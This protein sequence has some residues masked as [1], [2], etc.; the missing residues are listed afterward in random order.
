MQ[1]LAWDGWRVA[2]REG[3]SGYPDFIV[4]DSCSQRAVKPL[5]S[6]FVDPEVCE[7]VALF[8]MSRPRWRCMLQRNPE[9]RRSRARDTVRPPYED[10]SYSKLFMSTRV[11]KLF[12]TAMPDSVSRLLM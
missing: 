10:Q 8:T 11:P 4:T 1:T 2:S 12:D 7:G 3:S 6:S 9:S 5:S